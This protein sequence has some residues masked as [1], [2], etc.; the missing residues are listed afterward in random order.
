MLAWGKGGGGC[1]GG[2]QQI[3]LLKGTVKFLANQGAHLLGF[4]VISI[5]IACRE[6]IGADQDPALNLITKSLRSALGRHRAQRFRVGSAV[7][8][9]DAVVAGQIG[10]RLRWGNHVVG[11][12]AGLEARA[13]DIHQF[14]TQAGQLFSSSSDRGF[15]LWLKP[16]NK[17]LLE[18]ADFE[19][20]NR[21]I[22]RSAVVRHRHIQAGG[23]AGV[24]ACNH[25]KHS[26]GISHGAAE[27]TDLIQG[28][29]KGH[30]APAANAPIG[31]FQAH[32]ATKAGGLANGA[33]GVR[34]QGNITLPGRYTGRAAA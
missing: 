6:G 30:Q 10:G 34:A 24:M 5:D 15:H 1:G 28:T 29:G 2:Q 19:P 27:G 22:Q 23:I 33:A 18:D 26:S 20:L 3:H 9:F 11:G 21:A 25:L 7:A 17:S 8:V 14:T 31:G 4:F 12:N 16:L 13:T 32:H